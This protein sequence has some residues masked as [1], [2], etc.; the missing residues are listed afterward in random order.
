MV[1]FAEFGSGDWPAWW[2]GRVK[3]VRIT[4][5]SALLWP[6]L[7][8]QRGWHSP[9]NNWQGHWPR[10]GSLLPHKS[11]NSHCRG[12]IPPPPVSNTTILLCFLDILVN[13]QKCHLEGLPHSPSKWQGRPAPGHSDQSSHSGPW[14][15]GMQSRDVF[16]RSLRH[17]EVWDGRERRV[18][19][20]G[21]D[22]QHWRGAR[23]PGMW[24]AMVLVLTTLP[25]SVQGSKIVV[26]QAERAVAQRHSKGN[27]FLLGS[28]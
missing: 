23:C 13:A 14:R 27:W 1:V 11:W 28:C 19:G 24:Q 7:N 15:P 4:L 22:C 25:G 2:R 3:T 20:E 8:G 26:C 12:I 17:R 9:R 16:T 6:A 21:L 5:K 18:G 10:S